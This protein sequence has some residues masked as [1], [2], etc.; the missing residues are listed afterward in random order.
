[1]SSRTRPAPSLTETGFC[2][3][4]ASRNSST[5][6]TRSS[7]PSTSGCRDGER[8]SMPAGMPRSR[9]MSARDLLGHELA[10]EARLR[11]L[12][13]VDLDAVGLAHDVGAPAQAAAEALH[14]DALGRLAHLGDQAALARVVADVGQRGGLGQRD[15]RRLRQRAVAHRARSSR[16]SRGR[17]ARRRS[18]R[19]ATSRSSTLPTTSGS[20]SIGR[21]V[22]LEGEVGEVRQRAAGAVAADAVAPDLRLDRDVL[23]HLRVPVVR[24]LRA[25]EERDHADA[26]LGARVVQVLAGVHDLAEAAARTGSRSGRGRR[27]RRPARRPPGR[28]PRRRRR[29]MSMRPPT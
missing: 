8:R 3:P 9:A 26:R 13:D 16:A 25:D 10:A 4:V 15:L 12:R 7:A 23:L 6:I 5:L 29:A 24:A 14:D 21:Q 28:P 20:G 19:R 2:Q 22:A 11:A 1:M 18:G 27:A 17:S